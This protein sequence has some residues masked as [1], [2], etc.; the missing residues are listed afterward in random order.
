MSVGARCVDT[1]SDHVPL[2]RLNFR[3]PPFDRCEIVDDMLLGRDRY[4]EV[5]LADCGCNLLVAD[6]S[7]VAALLH[8]IAHA[9]N[10]ELRYY[11]TSSV[12]SAARACPER[13]IIE[14]NPELADYL[15]LE[16]APER[17]DHRTEQQRRAAT[18]KPRPS[19]SV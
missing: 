16:R 11:R 6:H 7:Q 9:H 13:G 19:S 17:G 8:S 12:T 1:E 2:G 5:Y 4:L 14:I 10:I 18:A 15:R 3:R